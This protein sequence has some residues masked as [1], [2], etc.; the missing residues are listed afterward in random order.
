MSIPTPIVV[1]AFLLVGFLYS[2]CTP[3]TKSVQA[4]APPLSVEVTQVKMGPI[5]R[6]ITLPAQVRANQQAVLYAKVTGYLKHC[7]VDRGD[8][9]RADDLIAELE[10]PELQAD[11]T[12]AR[13]DVQVAKTDFERLSEAG[14]R[15]P[16]LVVPLTVE[17]ARAKLE[18]AQATLS[19]QETLLGFTQLKAPFAGTVTKRWADLGALIPA[20]TASSS[21]TAS[22]V[23][24]LM[25]FHV[26]RAEVYVPEPEVPPVRTG[27]PAELKVDELPGKVFSGQISRLGY[28]L[29]ETTRCMPIEIDIP[30]ADGALR[31]GMFATAKLSVGSKASAP[32]L[33]IDA[34]VTEKTRTSVFLWVSGKAHKVPVKVG[35]EDGKNVEVIEG[36]PPEAE[37]IRTGKLPLAEGM[38]V[39]RKVSK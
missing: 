37:V 33:P 13:A 2:G 18:T 7:L 34:L 31:P 35:F 22:A 26:V 20:A 12:R 25:D 27:M 8:T 39:E 29:D 30:N 1:A 10:A 19:R 23:V 28:A 24:T 32:L 11:A 38:V 4:E 21:P 6:S 17:N 16:D 5:T 9:V 36:V 3:E 14:R 15:A